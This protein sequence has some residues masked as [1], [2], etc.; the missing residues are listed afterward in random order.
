MTNRTNA[1]SGLGGII[2]GLVEAGEFDDGGEFGGPNL[3]IVPGR[4]DWTE[5]QWAEHDAKILAARQES[6]RQ[7]AAQ[8]HARRLSAFEKAGWPRRALDS[9]ET[10]DV[11][12]PGIV[13]A[14][15]WK[16]AEECVLVLSGPPGCGKTTAAARWGL[17][18]SWA[19]AFLRATTFAA[20]SR[21]DHERRSSWLEA[22]ALVLDDL[23]AEYADTKGNFL[24]DLDEL[25]DT[26]YGAKRPLLITT[27]CT[28]V[29]FKGRYGKRVV[30]RIRECGSWF[31][32]NSA[33]LRKKP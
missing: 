33:S 3:A 14:I 27:N 9:A 20:S 16:P 5:E 17:T 24:V 11:S 25:V 29:E 13:R 23:G 18:R 26:F 19:P 28:D 21:Y 7:E 2:A 10:A 30:D 12:K 6:D 4:G 1:A 15:A 31:S 22:D 32:V 8:D